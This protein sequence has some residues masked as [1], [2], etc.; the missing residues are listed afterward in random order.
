MD[1][2]SPPE[3]NDWLLYFVSVVIQFLES[4]IT[5]LQCFEWEFIAI[6]KLGVRQ[7]LMSTQVVKHH[8]LQIWDDLLHPG[9]VWMKLWHY[10]IIVWLKICTK[11]F[12]VFIKQYNP[13][14]HRAKRGARVL[15]SI[16]VE[17][18]TRVVTRE[19][20]FRFVYLSWYIYIK[21]QKTSKTKNLKQYK[22]SV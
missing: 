9:N 21:L 13:L 5:G 4:R 7:F 16:C 3:Q 18:V 11:C 1:G 12:C 19:K 14:A 20:N 8:N 2:D 10:F 6:N 15:I 22:P 17:P